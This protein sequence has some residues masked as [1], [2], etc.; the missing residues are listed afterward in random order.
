MQTLKVGIKDIKGESDNEIVT[1]DPYITDNFTIVLKTGLHGGQ[2]CLVCSDYTTFLPPCGCETAYCSQCLVDSC[3]SMVD[4]IRSIL[5]CPNSDCKQEWDPLEIRR[6]AKFNDSQF[7]EFCK[8]LAITL[9]NRDPYISDCPGCGRYYERKDQAKSSVYCI[10]CAKEGR[11]ARYCIQCN[12]TWKTSSSSTNC[13]NPNCNS[14]S[15]LSLLPLAK[16]KQIS[17]INNCPSIRLCTS[18]G[19][20]IEHEEKCKEIKCIA[21]GKIF[22]FVCL[23]DWR[24]GHLSDQCK[25]APTQTTVPHK[26]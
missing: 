2:S 11:P 14:T 9:V 13:G 8:T 18:C 1:D 6:R 23:I 21:C 10:M 20:V 15:V 24:S 17:W 12:L 19:T 3:S 7:N 16:P 5:A 22:C 4:H 26:K 25:P